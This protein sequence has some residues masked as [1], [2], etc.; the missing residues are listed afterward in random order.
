MVQVAV[1]ILATQPHSELPVHPNLTIPSLVDEFGNSV[2]GVLSTPLAAQ[3]EWTKKRRKEMSE[4]RASECTHP[5][6]WTSDPPSTLLSDEQLLQIARLDLPLPAPVSFSAAVE[7]TTAAG[8][9]IRTQD[10]DEIVPPKRPNE[11]GN[12]DH[13]FRPLQHAF[14]PPAEV[15]SSGCVEAMEGLRPSKPRAPP[16]TVTTQIGIVLAVTMPHSSPIQP[17]VDPMLLQLLQ[18]ALSSEF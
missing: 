15:P 3:Q 7:R 1:Q 13:L 16:Q 5:P 8:R 12:A 6:P 2:A 18:N 10:N 4:A 14:I 17:E 9:V 11:F